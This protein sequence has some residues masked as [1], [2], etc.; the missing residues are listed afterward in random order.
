MRTFSTG[1]RIIYEQTCEKII[2]QAGLKLNDSIPPC[3][4]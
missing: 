4:S 3:L 1:K 2:P